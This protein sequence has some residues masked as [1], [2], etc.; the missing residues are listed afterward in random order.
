MKF[1]LNVCAELLTIT[2]WWHHLLSNGG[3]LFILLLY[4]DVLVLYGVF[5]VIE[6]VTYAQNVFKN[7]NITLV[8][9]TTLSL[10]TN[11]AHLC[12]YNSES[13]KNDFSIS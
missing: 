3:N 5:C 13:F 11:I 2:Y 8:Y 1:V 7:Q 12:T 4:S 9:K 10:E 6:K